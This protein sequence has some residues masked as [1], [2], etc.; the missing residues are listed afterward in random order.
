LISATCWPTK[1]EAWTEIPLDACGA[2]NIISY[3]LFVGITIR[4][5]I[6]TQRIINKAIY[7]YFTKNIKIKLD[8]KIIESGLIEINDDVRHARVCERCARG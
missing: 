6:Y 8:H 1:A 4:D 2:P 7:L 3:N 5:S